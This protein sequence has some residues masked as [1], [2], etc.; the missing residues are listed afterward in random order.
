M[1]HKEDT[2]PWGKF[3]QF[4]W[5]E[6]TTVKIITVN[7]GQQLSIQR[8][9]KRS[10]FWVALDDGL[11]TYLEG[12]WRVLHKGGTFH[13]AA[14]KIHSIRNEYKTPARFLEIAFGH[15]DE[16]DIERLEDKYGRS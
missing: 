9:Q 16:D 15:F 7:P 2:R 6:K 11:I 5:N 14:N 10:E 3:E 4:T 8:H 1:Y 13:I 12:E